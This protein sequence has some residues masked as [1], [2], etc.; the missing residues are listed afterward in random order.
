[1]G[2]STSY[3]K[4]GWRILDVAPNGPADVEGSLVQGDLFEAN[5]DGATVVWCAIRPVSGRR[6]ATRLLSHLR[7]TIPPGG[8]I[9]LLLPAFLLPSDEP[10]VTLRAGYVFSEGPG[11]ERAAQLYGGDGKL[12]GPR[13]VLDYLLESV[14]TH[15][16]A[17]AESAAVSGGVAELDGESQA[18]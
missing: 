4:R 5:L 6:L 2:N 9:R 16:G 8:S 15:G 11:D 10:G 1:M 12:G 3:E 13:V 7:R 14:P 18:E 17:P